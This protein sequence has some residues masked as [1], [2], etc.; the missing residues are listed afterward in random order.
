M[1][2]EEIIK[3]FMRIAKEEV[4]ELSSGLNQGYKFAAGLAWCWIS[5][6]AF[7]CA[8][9][10]EDSPRRRIDQFY[11]EFGGRYNQYYNSMPNEFKI[12]MVGLIRY[13][14]LDMRPSHLTD[15]TIKIEDARNLKQVLNVIYRVRNNL[16]HGG[17]NMNEERDMNLVLYC[18]KVLYYILEKILRE[19]RLI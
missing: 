19:E 17:K 1:S 8:R 16:F 15:S 9:Y 5:F 10:N 14:I 2:R 11:N 3:G 4:T 6:E 18:S 12:S 13:E 7:T